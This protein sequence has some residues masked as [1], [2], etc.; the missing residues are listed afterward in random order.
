M[1]RLDSRTSAGDIL[2]KALGRGRGR[3][4][5]IAVAA[6]LVALAE[7][8]NT[9]L[10]AQEP[11]PRQGK[12]RLQ[13]GKVAMTYRIS[14]EAREMVERLSQVWHA[15]RGDVVDAA[16][17][18]LSELQQRG[19]AQPEWTTVVQHSLRRVSVRQGQET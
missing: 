5:D 3:P 19:E 8:D 6:S 7:Q 1:A 12:G 17:R 15:Q 4:E 10:P 2:A 13:N 9:T 18:L 11:H 16:I 14:P